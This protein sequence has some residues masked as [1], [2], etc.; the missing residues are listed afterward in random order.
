MITKNA[1][2]VAAYQYDPL[3]RRVEKIA[4][5]TTT[6]WA[7]DIED[8][9][10][11][12]ATTA[13][14]TSTTRFVHGPGIDEPMAQE[15]VA[16]GAVTYLHADALGS[17]SKH[18]N[19]SAATLEAITYDPWGDIQSGNP[20]LYS[21]T[22]REWDSAAQM[23]FYRAR[24]YDQ[25]QGRFISEDPLGYGAGPNF[26]SYAWL[27]PAVWTDPNGEIPVALPIFFALCLILEN[28]DVISTDPG[29][30]PPPDIPNP[31]IPSMKTPIKFVMSM[32]KQG[33]A[34]GTRGGKPFTRKT[35]REYAEKNKEQNGGSNKCEQCEIVT[36][37]AQRT[38]PGPR[39]YNERQ[40]DH[41]VS[42]KNGGAG[43][44]T[45]IQILCMKCNVT[46]GSKED[47]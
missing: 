19:A 33:A 10:R 43:D 4:G 42:R 39:P 3:G 35:K 37:P 34:G 22:G 15:E 2:T 11:Q 36:P 27:N 17:I 9:L 38:M 46:K 47:E 23:H 12:E 45:N 8:I 28:P 1:A 13:A 14:A 25:R 24:W 18:T 30:P 6:T 5:A 26:F 21:F 16:N 41:V 7:Y 29:E 32:A 31:V 20:G 44:E 40:Y